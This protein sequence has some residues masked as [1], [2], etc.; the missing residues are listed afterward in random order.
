MIRIVDKRATKKQLGDL[1][2]GNTF[3]FNDKLYM[4]ISHEED[5]NSVLLLSEGCIDIFNPYTIFVTKVDIEIN[6]L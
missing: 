3:M 2:V 4:K 1:A 5:A 6:I